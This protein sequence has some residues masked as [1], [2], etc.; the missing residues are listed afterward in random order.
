MTPEVNLN[1]VVKIPQSELPV[2]SAG[3]GMD[4]KE[5]DFKGQIKPEFLYTPSHSESN[6]MN[7]LDRGTFNDDFS[8]TRLIPV[9]ADLVY[10]YRAV[11][12][13]FFTIPSQGDYVCSASVLRPRIVV[14]AG[15]CLHSGANGSNGF[16]TNFKFVPAFRDGTAP[17]GTW[18]SS[19]AIV[20]STWA[21]GGGA[22]PNAADYGMLE[23]KDQNIGGTFYT[24]GSITGY[25]GYQ[26]LSLMPNHTNMLGYPCNLDSC[27]KMHQVTAQSANAVSPNNV[28]YGSDM[29]G[30]SSGGPWVQNFGVLATGQIGGLNTGLNRIVGVTSYG[31]VSLDPKVQGAS[32]FDSRFTS[33]LDTIC[34][35]KSGN[36]S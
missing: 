16:Y 17:I 23:I 36:C 31:Y 6:M 32:I 28:E 12:K 4:G 35:H 20:T 10:P 3:T 9:T 18:T 26:T 30:G 19:Y 2:K 27:Q 8:S 25:L 15:H 24:I 1:Q 13:L 7:G 21:T 33:V 14:T 11:G 34:T 22:V 5:P 29:R